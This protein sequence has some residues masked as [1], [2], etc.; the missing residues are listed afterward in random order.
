MAELTP[1]VRQFL[2][3][4][5]TTG[6]AQ[7]RSDYLDKGPRPRTWVGKALKAGEWALGGLADVTS[8]NIWLPLAEELVYEDPVALYRLK[9]LRGDTN[10]PIFAGDVAEAMGLRSQ[11]GEGRASRFG[12]GVARFGLSVAGDPLTYVPFGA[13]TKAGRAKRLLKAAQAQGREIVPG[14]KVHKLI[15]EALGPDVLN[16]PKEAV[17]AE[18]RSLKARASGELELVDAVTGKRNLPWWKIDP[19]TGKARTGRGTDLDPVQQA[20]AA[21]KARQGAYFYWGSS[22]AK[23]KAFDLERMSATERREMVEKGLVEATGEAPGYRVTDP[24]T[25]EPGGLKK[26]Y[27]GSPAHRKLTEVLGYD[28]VTGKKPPEY[29]TIRTV[30]QR[31]DVQYTREVVPGSEGT[32]IIR[33]PVKLHVTKIGI[34]GERFAIPPH[35]PP[36]AKAE[37]KRLFDKWSVLSKIDLNT[38]LTE[39]ADKHRPLIEAARDEFSRLLAETMEAYQKM[40]QPLTPQ[41][42]IRLPALRQ[43][44]NNL[45]EAWRVY[46][47]EARYAHDVSPPFA[48]YVQA[49]KNAYDLR[50]L[51]LLKQHPMDV[52]TIQRLLALEVTKLPEFLKKAGR[53]DLLPYARYGGPDT[54]KNIAV[55]RQEASGLA[56][57]GDPLPGGA[58]PGL[59]DLLD[60]IRDYHHLLQREGSRQDVIKAS[61]KALYAT[62]KHARIKLKDQLPP[63]TMKLI[64]KTLRDK[65][66]AGVSSAEGKTLAQQIKA[67]ERSL[68]S[69]SLPGGAEFTVPLVGTGPL[70]ERVAEV[71]GRINR[72]GLIQKIERAA[73]R[74][75]ST[76]TGNVEYDKLVANFK[77]IALHK[78]GIEVKAGVEIRKRLEEISRASGGKYTVKQLESYISKLVDRET[79][80]VPVRALRALIGPVAEMIQT[81][82]FRKT[83]AL[84]KALAPITDDLMEPISPATVLEGAEPVVE[85]A[86][87]VPKTQDWKVDLQR[88]L[89]KEIWDLTEEGSNWSGKIDDW[90]HFDIELLNPTIPE[91]RAILKRLGDVAAARTYELDFYINN[92][93]LEEMVGR[94]YISS[95]AEAEGGFKR[96]FGTS[97][98]PKK[99]PG[100]IKELKGKTVQESIANFQ[101]A[102]GRY[103]SLA[104]AA[105]KKL[106]DWKALNPQAEE[107]IIAGAPRTPLKE[108]I[109]EEDE[110]QRILERTR[111]NLNSYKPS[112]VGRVVQGMRDR[113]MKNELALRSAGLPQIPATTEAEFIFEN[114]TLEAKQEIEAFLLKTGKLR[115]GFKQGE[116]RRELLKLLRREFTIVDHG[117]VD[118]LRYSGIISERVAAT[119]KGKRGLER[120]LKLHKTRKIS[121]SEFSDAVYTLGVADVNELASKGWFP[122]QQQYLPARALAIPE[123][124]KLDILNKRRAGLRSQLAEAELL[125]K[126]RYRKGNYNKTTQIMGEENVA[127]IMNELG[128]VSDEISQITNKTI[129]EKMADIPQTQVFHDDPILSSTMMGVR[130]QQA[131]TAEEFY[132]ELIRRGVGVAVDQ[133][134]QGYLA[135]PK[136]LPQLEGYLFPPEVAR[137]LSKWQEFQYSDEVVSKFLRMHDTVQDAWKAW[138]LAIF[139]AYHTR[140]FVG[141]LWNNWLAGISDPKWYLMASKLQSYAW[142]KG[143]KGGF[144]FT[145]GLGKR[146][147]PD[148]LIQEM[149]H[150]GVLDRGFIPADITRTLS[151]EMKKGTFK[152]LGRGNKVIEFGFKVGQQIENQSRMAHFM[153]KLSEGMT[154]ED[155]AMSVKK[156][157]FDYSDLTD[158]EKNVMKRIFPF[159][160]WTR[161]NVPLQLQHLIT[162]P[163]RF[164]IPYKARRAIESKDESPNEKYLPQWVIE[165]Y[166]TRIRYDEKNK[167]YEYFL[168]NAWLPASDLVKLLEVHET[169]VNMLT[170]VPKELIQQIFNYDFFLKKKIQRFSGEKDRLNIGPVKLDADARFIHGLKL[171]RALREADQLSR[172]D[173]D[174]WTKVTEF[175]TSKTYT[176]DERRAKLSSHRE[177]EEEMQTIKAA[178]NREARKKPRNEKEINRIRKL[179]RETAERY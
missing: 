70:A 73:K 35:L 131:I 110:I 91:D 22:K 23:A 42:A 94:G 82:G 147:T 179:I 18:A 118:K 76:A 170:P 74:T 132:G 117:A 150:R 99:M 130:A 172:P 142:S 46:K 163:A 153:A 141:N 1:E 129:P 27:V 120:L 138:T 32:E 114:L 20:I 44:N 174:F 8:R 175:M 158:F 90:N 89:E 125:S 65:K 36:E 157:L 72:I 109:P 67:K 5:T 135:A 176:Y 101:E 148:E 59:D 3:G 17:E 6:L 146:W 162:Q 24:I 43:A 152:N 80:G 4:G 57:T 92:P 66:I 34:P 83:E 161:K 78:A 87:Q 95:R 164:S 60:N 159:Y 15:T 137:A 30:S 167:T 136:T 166:P 68:V 69:V 124:R 51:D 71:F 41:Q 49:A 106:N 81:R 48:E 39:I 93:A 116:F 29:R 54:G 144:H 168:G 178:L 63:E 134:P 127:R 25:P 126:F 97:K 2:R 128:D 155:A 37:L 140:N 123:R 84:K 105:Y 52:P 151:Q 13:L 165:N 9:E 64:E 26:V 14:S 104:R 10:H 177:I 121:D 19:R 12:K 122:W 50:K 113:A 85:R 79:R 77:D 143:R 55:L 40:G 103:E 7:A 133:A 102:K 171:V 107:R 75:F 156:Y 53:E 21:E 56:K 108:M 160:T 61:V 11:P 33:K 38:S 58:I 86:T 45:K 119:L 112:P 62:K 149:R 100:S 47:R 88:Q 98:K 115:A 16:V 169:A 139:P 154:A 111:V 31:G 96:A 28:P 145:D 173:M